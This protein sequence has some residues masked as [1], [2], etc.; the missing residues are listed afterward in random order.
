MSPVTQVM[1]NGLLW[2]LLAP[3][4]TVA[5]II[6]AAQKVPEARRP[7]FGKIALVA[8]IAV[9]WLGLAGLPKP[10]SNAE[11]WIPIGI[12]VTGL[13]LI[14][15]E[16]VLPSAL[17]RWAGPLVAFL[18]L[19]FFSYKLLAP[20]Q[21][22]WKEGEVLGLLTRSEWVIDGLAVAGL[23]LVA[24]HSAAR[25]LPAPAVLG[26]LALTMGGLAV[27]VALTGSISVAE[28]LG[29]AAVAVVTT[30]L[31][32][33]RFSK[34]APGGVSA[35]GVVLLSLFASYAHFYVETPRPGLVLLLIA[36]I[37][38]L[39]GSRSARTTPAVLLAL[40]ATLVPVASGLWVSWQSDVAK[41]AAQAGDSDDD[42]YGY[43]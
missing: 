43:Y 22:L 23:V 28:K 4:A 21:G 35:I 13:L 26:P 8:G 20:L 9:A 17:R 7:L 15:T 42:P 16:Q 11:G 34:T 33:W 39:A 1:I 40:A 36:P 29:A 37:G 41:Q 18:S 3:A 30:G 6:L 19:V 10:S 32:G 24:V 2:I 14:L 31:L 27:S 38:M 25:K 12:F 5:V